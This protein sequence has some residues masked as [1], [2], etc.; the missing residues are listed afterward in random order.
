MEEELEILKKYIDKLIEA[1]KEIKEKDKVI[2]A[3][4]EQLSTP[5]HSTEWV[6]DFYER[7]VKNERLQ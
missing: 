1:K 2:K 5:I 4:A 7:K 6:I 3:M